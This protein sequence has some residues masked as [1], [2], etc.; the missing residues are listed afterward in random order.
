VENAETQPIEA[1]QATGATRLQ[2]L[3]YGILSQVLPRYVAYPLYRREV[4]I[5][6][7]VILGYMAAGGLDQQ[8]QI[9]ISLFPEH[10]L[11]T[12]I[13]AIYLIVRVVDYLSAFLRNRLI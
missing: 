9:A 1:L 5:R 6:E 7:V 11:I 8:I 4:N 12:L 13:I 10:R 2:I 3:L